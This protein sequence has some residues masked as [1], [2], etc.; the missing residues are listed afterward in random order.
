M[1][2]QLDSEAWEAGVGSSGAEID[3]GVQGD[4]VSMGDKERK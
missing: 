3:R 4:D 2:R 1:G